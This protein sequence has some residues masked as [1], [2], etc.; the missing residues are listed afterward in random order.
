M[1]VA[2]TLLGCVVWLVW[3]LLLP[4]VL[5]SLVL[6]VLQP[7][8]HHT[9][10]RAQSHL[11]ISSTLTFSK[12]LTMKFPF[13]REHLQCCRTACHWSVQNMKLRVRVPKRRAWR[14]LERPL[15]LT[16][17]VLYAALEIHEMPSLACRD[18]ARDHFTTWLFDPIILKG[19]LPMPCILAFCGIR[20]SKC[21]KW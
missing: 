17:L 16:W 7:F 13:I 4:A 8:P 2:W 21:K 15:C 1:K 12:V 9:K 18:L 10:C 19:L 3:A 6:R 20:F 5:Y 11:R 14:V